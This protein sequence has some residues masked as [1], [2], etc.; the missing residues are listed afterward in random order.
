MIGH[1]L[2]VALFVVST[3][4]GSGASGIRDGDATSAE[5]MKP[6]DIA[7]DP[8]GNIYV[9]DAAAQRI[10]VVS[11]SGDVTTLAGSGSLKYGDMWVDG[12][13]QDGPALQA[14]FNRPSAVA[15]GPDGGVYVADALNHCIRLIKDGM[16]STYAGSPKDTSGADGPLARASFRK[17]RALAFDAAGDLYVADLELGIRR[18]HD[19][20][21]TTLTTP[22][23]MDKSYLSIAFAGSGNNETMFVGTSKELVAFDP[24]LHVRWEQSVAAN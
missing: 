7:T 13:Y 21:V 9:A 19:G 20:T 24:D 15:V 8:Q 3:L 22:V 14:Q 2:A 16:V 18:I 5:F 6:I 23:P 11:P 4:A 10:R 1:L 17:P 12:G